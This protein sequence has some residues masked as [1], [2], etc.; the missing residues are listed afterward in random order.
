MLLFSPCNMSLCYYIIYFTSVLYSVCACQS[1][2]QEHVMQGNSLK[3]NVTDHWTVRTGHLDYND[4]ETSFCVYVW[5]C[6]VPVDNSSNQ[7]KHCSDTND[8]ML[9]CTVTSSVT[10]SMISVHPIIGTPRELQD[11]RLGGRV[12]CLAL[13][14]KLIN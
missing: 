10:R 11:L 3:Q 1:H 13:C 4:I 14:K 8:Q 5:L 2:R 7:T 12:L 9:A 6:Y